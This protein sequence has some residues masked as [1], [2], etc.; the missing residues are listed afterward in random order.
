[1]PGSEAI[2][3]SEKLLVVDVV[4]P[5]RRLHGVGVDGNQAEGAVGLQLRED[6]RNCVVGRVGF[7]D[8]GKG[9]TRWTLISFLFP[10]PV[11]FL[12]TSTLTRTIR[13]N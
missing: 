6:A 13:Y 10:F 9:V 2:H 11:P 12:S 4:V 7:E 5:L 8:G 1:M 3:Y